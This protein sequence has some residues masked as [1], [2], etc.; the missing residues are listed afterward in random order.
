M[1]KNNTDH[2]T[3]SRVGR[4]RNKKAKRKNESGL[5]DNFIMGMTNQTI[6]DFD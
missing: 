4:T 2:S 1:E 3:N 6:D 5:P